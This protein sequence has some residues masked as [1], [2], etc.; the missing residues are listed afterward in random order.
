MTKILNLDELPTEA[1]ERSIQLKGVKH[2][3]QPLS[4][5]AFIDNRKTALAVD[6]NDP[7]SSIPGIITLIC[8]VFPTLRE[9]DLKALN[10]PA[11]NAIMDFISKRGDEIVAEGQPAAAEG[12]EKNE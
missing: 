11:I 9:E 3:M 6:A 5:Q 4:L 10:F 2:D 7:A 8:S 12:A 1:V